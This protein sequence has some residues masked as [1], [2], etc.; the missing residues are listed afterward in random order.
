M[1]KTYTRSELIE[2]LGQPF[3]E[4]NAEKGRSTVPED[5]DEAFQP[6][7]HSGERHEAPIRGVPQFM[8]WNCKNPNW[9]LPDVCWAHGDAFADRWM[10]LLRCPDHGGNPFVVP[11]PM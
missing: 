8:I 9:D 11:R 10:L 7:R 6:G 2:L 3:V 5:L 4:D 1:H